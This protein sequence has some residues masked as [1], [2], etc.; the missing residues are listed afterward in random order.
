M[1]LLILLLRLGKIGSKTQ[2]R[3]LTSQPKLQ[4][5][6][7]GLILFL[8]IVSMLLL[9]PLYLSSSVLKKKSKLLIKLYLK[10]SKDLLLM[11]STFLNLFVVSVKFMLLVFLL[12]Q[13]LLTSLITMAVL[14]SMQVYIGI[15]LNLATLKK[16]KR[17]SQDILTSTSGTTSLKQ[18]KVVSSLVFHSLLIII[19]R[20]MMRLLNININVHSFYLAES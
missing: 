8:T 13:V 6:L 15:V 4:E 10:L 3:T 18:L 7:I 17:N 9:H 19:T 12:K 16:K 1:N 11:L 5:L 20:N 14:L 2:V